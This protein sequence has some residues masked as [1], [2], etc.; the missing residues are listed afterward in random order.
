M[1]AVVESYSSNFAIATLPIVVGGSFQS[2]EKQITIEVPTGLSNS[3]LL[4]FYTTAATRR[5]TL[6]VTTQATSLNDDTDITE[7][8]Y[9]EQNDLTL[10]TSQHF[11]AVRQGVVYNPT[12]GTHT[13]TARHYIYSLSSPL[14]IIALNV[15]G[16][17]VSNVDI[18]NV[19]FDRS[20]G[21]GSG[22][23]YPVSN[24]SA[25]LKPGDFLASA[26]FAH[27]Y[28]NWGLYGQVYPDSIVNQTE[29]CYGHGIFDGGMTEM[30][31]DWNNATNSYYGARHVLL[32]GLPEPIIHVPLSFFG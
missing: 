29:G 1:A 7:D 23:S 6:T 3:V 24:L 19:S 14:Y 4:F 16:V 27:R 26:F 25:A 2:A 9:Y 13:I 28:T 12:A 10:E 20:V 8:K 31:L 11:A 21:I 22:Y 17:V 18:P 30:D 32:P 5:D 15:V